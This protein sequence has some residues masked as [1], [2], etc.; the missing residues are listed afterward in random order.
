MPATLPD[1]APGAPAAYS[2]LGREPGRVILKRQ[3]IDVQHTTAAA[4]QLRRDDGLFRSDSQADR[5]T[6]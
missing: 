3:R 6:F 5:L 1:V 2:F 4:R